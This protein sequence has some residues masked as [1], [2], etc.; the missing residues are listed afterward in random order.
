MVTTGHTEGSEVRNQCGDKFR[1]P[2]VA[3]RPANKCSYQNIFLSKEHN[4]YNT[5]INYEIR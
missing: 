5:G 4:L 3:F 1:N 2:N